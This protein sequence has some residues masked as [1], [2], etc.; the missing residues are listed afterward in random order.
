M[1]SDI[2]QLEYVDEKLRKMI[3]WLEESTGLEFT[4]TSRFRMNDDGVHGALPVRGLDLRC[5]SLEIGIAIESYVN[6]YW[7][8]DPERPGKKCCFL[9]GHD[10][11][12]HFHLQVHPNTEFKGKND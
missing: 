10:S 5:R 11:N 8:Y 4:E 2:A 6:K 1:K 3:T 7:S 12:L 9:H